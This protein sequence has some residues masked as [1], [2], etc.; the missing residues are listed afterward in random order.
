MPK[1]AVERIDG[2]PP[3][4]VDPFFKLIVDGNCYFDEFCKKMEKSGN[5]RQ[6]LEKLQAIMAEICL[7]RR[8]PAKWFQELKHRD[9]NDP[10]PD[11]EI[12]SKQ[13][14]LY[15][16]EDEEN[17]KIIV[18]GELKKGNKTQSKAIRKMREMKL[19]YFASGK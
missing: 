2:L 6:A 14:R 3:H 12:R 17:G 5:Q 10:Y 11:F 18:L 16:F 9:K 19:A 8:V 1:F 7:G 4:P 13:L 15:L